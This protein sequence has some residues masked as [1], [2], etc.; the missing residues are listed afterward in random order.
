MEEI[1]FEEKQARYYKH[2]AAEHFVEFPPGPLTVGEEPVKRVDEMEFATGTLRVISPTDC[3]KDRLASYY[4]FGDR[5]GLVQALMVAQ[6]NEIDV[7][8]I[9]GWSRSPAEGICV[10]RS[11]SGGARR[12][13]P[14]PSQPCSMRLA[15]P[16]SRC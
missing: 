6:E 12:R 4:H 3:V 16:A 10:R 14:M 9:K 7:D 1:G 15:S 8:E 5:Q 11:M 2:P 13:R